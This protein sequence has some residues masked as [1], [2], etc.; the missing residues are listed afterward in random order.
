MCVCV[1][2]CARLGHA[3]G[4]RLHYGGGLFSGICMLLLLLFSVFGAGGFPLFSNAA[5]SDC[6]GVYCTSTR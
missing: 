1:C 4:G 2:A 3:W 5:A 6:K